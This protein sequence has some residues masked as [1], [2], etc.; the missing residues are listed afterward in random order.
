MSITIQCQ[1]SR[2]ISVSEELAGQPT[3]C[4]SCGRRHLIPQIRR[5]PPVPHIEVRKAE[6]SGRACRDCRTELVKGAE[7]CHSCGLPHAT[8]KSVVEH[9]A[10]PVPAIPVP[11][12]PPHV[13]HVQ[14]SVPQMAHPFAGCCPTGR[15]PQGPFAAAMRIEKPVSGLA[16]VSMSCAYIAILLGIFTA[17]AAIPMVGYLRHNVSLEPGQAASVMTLV[18]GMGALIAMF[19]GVGLITGFLGLFHFG[20]RRCGAVLGM[21]LCFFV[22]ASATAN[23][24][25]LDK[26][27]RHHQ[28]AP[29]ADVQSNDCQRGDCG[30]HFGCDRTHPTHPAIEEEQIVPD[31]PE[32]PEQPQQR[33]DRADDEQK[34]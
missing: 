7:F 27:Y 5:V 1:C 28:V 34:F 12:M 16:K 21:I 20:R 2:V 22:G 25:K 4:P 13:P 33:Q 24:C 29:P 15:H 31:A 14:P 19:A 10:M 32:T 30:I 17:L 18:K 23:I 8:P 9:V 11:A 3:R 6:L 26:R